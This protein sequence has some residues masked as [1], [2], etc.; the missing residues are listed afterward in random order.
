V[1]RIDQR[2][3]GTGPDHHHDHHD[4]ASAADHHRDPDH[5]DASDHSDHPD[6][7]GT[8][9]IHFHHRGVARADDHHLVRVRARRGSQHHHHLDHPLNLLRRPMGA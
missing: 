8:G 2:H 3:P 9:L 4:D 1:Q 5:H 6:R 7:H